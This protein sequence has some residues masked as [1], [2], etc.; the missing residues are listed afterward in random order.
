MTLG[1]FQL[2]FFVLYH[3][4][5][6]LDSQPVSIPH[7]LVDAELCN[8]PVHQVAHVRPVI[9]KNHGAGA[10]PSIFPAKYNRM[11]ATLGATEYKPYEYLYCYQ[12][13]TTV[14]R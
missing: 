12:F 4:N 7:Q 11:G 5:S 1:V 10:H 14:I 3:L 9:V 2:P 6:G 13:L 8:L